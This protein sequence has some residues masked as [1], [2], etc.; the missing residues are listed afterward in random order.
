[1]KKMFL[2]VLCVLIWVNSFSQIVWLSDLDQAKKLSL[3]TGKLLVI[4]FWASWCGPCLAMDREL[5]GSAQMEE[6]AGNFVGVRVNTDYDRG[7][8]VYY[9][10]TAIPKV[11]IALYNGEM[12]WEKVGFSGS[13][14]YLDIFKSIP[15]NVNSLFE[16]IRIKS[17]NEKNPDA[18]LRAGIEHQKTGRNISGRTLREAFL[19]ESSFL[20]RKA[21]KLSQDNLF[22][23]KA[24]L[25]SILIDV[26][27][28]NPKKALNAIN[29]GDFSGDDKEISELK[30]F[31]SAI[32]YKSL[33]EEEN[34]LKVKEKITNT[35]YLTELNK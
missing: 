3:S 17:E 10:A 27:R 24:E 19:T 34:F 32:C 28:N 29:K 1:M 20:I 2:P 9:G 13:T 31:V 4:D 11:V 8:A 26:Y 18:L 7:T 30:Y 6:I 12:I 21:G 23:Q 25:Y 35:E 14:E 16:S 5:W 33:K 15:E 22:K